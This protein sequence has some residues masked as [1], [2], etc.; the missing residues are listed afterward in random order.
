M[1]VEELRRRVIRR[2]KMLSKDRLRV[3]D[4]FMAYLEDR[5][6]NAATREL[7]AIPGLT[8]AVERA[9]RDVAAG[10]AVPFAKVR[11]DV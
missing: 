7:T 2:V 6:D 9:E 3:A 4:D 5:Q 1:T 10:K 8:Q 11:R